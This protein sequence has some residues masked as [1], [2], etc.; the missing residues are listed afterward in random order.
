MAGIVVEALGGKENIESVD[1]CFTRLRLKLK[2][3]DVVNETAL[4]GTGAAGVIKKGNNVQVIYGPKVNG[5]RNIVDKYLG[6]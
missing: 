6:N 4:K 2:N 5:I 1:N 3:I